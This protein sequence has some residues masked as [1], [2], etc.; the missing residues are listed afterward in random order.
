[1]S[2]TLQL[3]SEN[4]IMQ[5]QAQLNIQKNRRRVIIVQSRADIAQLLEIDKLE[6]AF[7]RVSYV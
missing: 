2:I 1:M 7:S 6:S 4:L 5:F 3:C